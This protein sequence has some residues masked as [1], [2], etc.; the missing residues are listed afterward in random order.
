MR[1]DGGSQN[2]EVF[3]IPAGIGVYLCGLYEDGLFAEKCEDT[4]L[5]DSRGT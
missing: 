5:T 4:R 1:G 2:C 3:G